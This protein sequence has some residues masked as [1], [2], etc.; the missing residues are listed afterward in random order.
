MD[1]DRARQ[2]VARERHRIEAALAD[3]S[4]D[5]RDD[6]ESRLDQTGESEESGAD[7]QIQMTDDAVAAGLRD[8][9]AAVERAEA[10]I[11]ERT[12]GRSIESGVRIP[13]ARL[14]AQP[15]AERT[16]EEQGR[17]ERGRG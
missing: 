4:A 15:L 3:L 16:V 14:E 12:Y 2:L 10:R 11:A 1:E 6:N 9:L 7:L 17:Y 13:D 5:D 8:E